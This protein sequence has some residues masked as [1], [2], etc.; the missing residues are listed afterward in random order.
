[1]L[2][3]QEASLSLF[4]AM[5]VFFN[6]RT[7]LVCLPA[8]AA[9][10][11]PAVPEEVE[12]EEEEDVALSRWNDY[13]RR[14]NSLFHLH[15]DGRLAN[16]SRSLVDVTSEDEVT[17]LLFCQ[18]EAEL[19]DT[20]GFGASVVWLH[21]EVEEEDE[22]EAAPRELRLDSNWIT[23]KEGE[24]NRVQL[25]EHFR[26]K[27][28]RSMGAVL[29][30]WTH[31]SGGLVVRR[32]PE[33][34]ERRSDLGGAVLTNT[35]LSWFPLSDLG[36]DGTQDGMLAEAFRYLQRSLNFSSV[37][38]TPDDGEWGVRRPL[39]PHGGDGDWYWSGMVGQLASGKADVST[40]GLTVGAER[41]EAIDF[42]VGV[43]EETVTLNM[44]RRED[45]Q[46]AAAAK[47][48]INAMAYL[49]VLSWGT[50]VAVLC[51]ALALGV[52]HSVI[53]SATAAPDPGGLAASFW[54]GVAIF[55]VDL[56]HL[57]VRL[58]SARPPSP[59]L[60]LALVSSVLLGSFMFQLYN[61]DLMARMTAGVPA[62]EIR[63]F[64]DVLSGGYLVHTTSGTS[65]EL[66]LATA[67]LG[68]AMA[69][70]HGKNLRLVDFDQS[71]KTVRRV[72]LM[73]EDPRNVF[74]QSVYTFAN[75]SRIVHLSD[76]EERVQ[77]HVGFGLQ[78]D[79][80]FRAAFDH[81]LVK[82]RQGGLLRRLE[83]KWIGSGRPG[84]SS[85]G[86]F[87]E[88]HPAV[89]HRNLL[90][91]TLVLLAGVGGSMILLLAEVAAEAASCRPAK[92]DKG[93]KGNVVVLSCHRQRA[94]K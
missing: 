45:G 5:A 47:E 38:V 32:S 16:S 68:S 81:H 11:A 70:V 71:T 46:G 3:S 34:W 4:D 83:D 36:P 89:G 41:H 91:P 14:S 78:K 82:M 59:P 52:C 72:Q 13:S 74:F 61:G 6:V 31:Q 87:V 12:E 29:G 19:R 1:M 33:V 27:G 69:E 10:A 20:F 7:V 8:A 88:E 15:Y 57:S 65:P 24:G 93:R 2:S 43:V 30:S 80:E 62:S 66:A 39:T 50:W 42:T 63:S 90:F 85:E 23:F 18:E 73:L 56:T 54:R 75:D 60:R 44:A 77:S 17:L 76:F 55:C 58:V 86:L 25:R 94:W 79:S 26:V 37:T 64:R 92:G 28:G 67:P 84:E 51:V 9:A 53:A 49:A 35:V 22:E 48:R 40:A 21:P